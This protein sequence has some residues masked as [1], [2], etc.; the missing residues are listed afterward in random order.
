MAAAPG[1]TA[2]AFGN[3]TG[4]YPNA[5]VTTNVVE[6]FIGHGPRR[7]FYNPDGTPITPGNYIPTGGR[8]L[9]KPDLTAADGVTTTP[10][11]FAPFFGTKSATTPHA[12][13]IAAL[14]LS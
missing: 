4:P 14:V 13:A 10:H 2:Y 1:D 6:Y 12:A 9:L 11:G 5:F 8:V 7:M 3:P